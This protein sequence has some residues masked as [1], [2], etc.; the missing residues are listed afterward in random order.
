M[1]TS[2]SLI[3][4]TYSD[5]EKLESLVSGNM[6]AKIRFN[7]THGYIIRHKATIYFKGINKNLKTDETSTLF[8]NAETSIKNKY[9]YKK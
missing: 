9:K 4:L 6:E 5:Q 3:R 8:I 7:L 1:A 2:S